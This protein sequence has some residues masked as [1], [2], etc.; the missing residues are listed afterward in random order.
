MECALSRELVVRVS[1]DPAIRRLEMRITELEKQVA[2][3][4]VVETELKEANK[5]RADIFSSL[6]AQPFCNLDP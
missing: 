5:E 4:E 2:E 3:M 6:R 1:R